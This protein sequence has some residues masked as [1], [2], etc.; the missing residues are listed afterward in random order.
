MFILEDAGLFME[1][2]E[3]VQMIEAIHPHAEILSTV[4]DRLDAKTQG[5][6]L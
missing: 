4:R 2:F 6:A 3:G 5:Q 1:A